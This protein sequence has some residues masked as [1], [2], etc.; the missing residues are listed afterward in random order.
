MEIGTLP[1]GEAPTRF[2]TPERT[3]AYGLSSGENP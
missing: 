3:T 2:G 1:Y